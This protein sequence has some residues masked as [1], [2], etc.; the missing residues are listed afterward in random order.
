MHFSKIR[1]HSVTFQESLLTFSSRFA[2]LYD[3]FKQGSKFTKP[4]PYP[5]YCMAET[6][7]PVLRTVSEKNSLLKR[8]FE[9]RIRGR[10]RGLKN[11]QT[12][13]TCKNHEHESYKCVV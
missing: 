13:A 6:R 9:P 1:Q 11:A 4:P 7:G 3:L 10:N 2:F 12:E 8:T 5:W